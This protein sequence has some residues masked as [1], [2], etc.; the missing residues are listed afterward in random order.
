MAWT[1]VQLD[2][3]QNDQVTSKLND[4]GSIEQNCIQIWTAHS[5]TVAITPNEAMTASDGTN[6]IP[7]MGAYYAIGGTD[8]WLC[9][10][11]IPRRDQTSP[12]L[13]YV[14]VQF[15]R[16]LAV[17][18]EGKSKWSAEISFSGEKYQQDAF[19]DIFGDAI[20]NSAGDTFD[21]SVKRTYYDEVLTLQY[22]TTSPP[23]LRDYRGYC[24][25]S[26][27]TLDLAGVSRSYDTRTLMLSDGEISTTLTLGDSNTSPTPVWTVKLVFLNREDTFVECV[28]DRGFHQLPTSTPNP[29][30]C[31]GGNKLN[32]NTT[33][34][35]QVLSGA[36][37]MLRLRTQ[38]GAET[39]TQTNLNGN[40]QALGS[41]ADPVFLC[42]YVVPQTDL[43][44][45]FS[46]F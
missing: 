21:P 15:L 29:N 36:A 3:Q 38:E 18:P 31:V 24:N 25:E 10:N 26:T 27:L 13:F 14:Q 17:K 8:Y 16:K 28:L 33:E 40:G 35:V 5:D 9:N 43:S 6:S 7:T 32:G 4:D 42:Y 22:Q 1:K 2:I 44:P 45:L 11:I 41:G 39:A 19:V 23:D 20:T 12:F 46:G 30:V 34:T 37:S